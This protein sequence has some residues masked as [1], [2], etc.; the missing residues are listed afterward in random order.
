MLLLERCLL[1]VVLAWFVGIDCFFV[2]AIQVQAEGKKFNEQYNLDRGFFVDHE[3]ESWLAERAWTGCNV[4]EVDETKPFQWG[5]R[6][7]IKRRS[8]VP[9][10]TTLDE[11]FDSA[12]DT[13]IARGSNNN[14]ALI[15]HRLNRTGT[16]GYLKSG[17][18][19]G[20]VDKSLDLQQLHP[21]VGLV[22]LAGWKIFNY[23]RIAPEYD[24]FLAQGLDEG[25][26]MET[27]VYAP[28]RNGFNFHSHQGF[29]FRPIRGKKLFVLA[30]SSRS[31]LPD[32]T[33]Q[34]LRDDAENSQ[35]YFDMNVLP[36]I[37]LL[38]KYESWF[39][40][41]K[42][43]QFCLV[44]EGDELMVPHYWWHLTVSVGDSLSFSAFYNK[45]YPA[46]SSES[47]TCP[48]IGPTPVE[49]WLWTR[50]TWINCISTAE[51]P[52]DAGD[53]CA[54]LPLAPSNLSLTTPSI[55]DASYR[56]LSSWC[57]EDGND[58][59]ADQVL[60]VT[61]E[62]FLQAAKEG[63]TENA[64][65]LSLWLEVWVALARLVGH[66]S[67]V[68]SLQTIDSRAN[69]F[70]STTMGMLNVDKDFTSK[71]VLKN[72]PP[73]Q[74]LLFGSETTQSFLATGAHP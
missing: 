26:D 17:G 28:S 23:E 57:S 71:Q 60:Q 56:F 10:S 2:N 3:F 27:D 53:Y 49:S 11:F 12:G 36:S 31:S 33:P 61:A 38:Q 20:R 45:D 24:D 72:C 67:L 19:S 1:T 55:C 63:G 37:V 32:E 7:L 50:R 52:V 22:G 41:T 35:F 44:G 39:R 62:Q 69:D 46:A 73:I 48:S 47:E 25:T 15:V 4:E 42:G 54:H 16:M 6:P 64:H 66:Q 59:K 5:D 9:S 68:T 74:R 43:L 51:K 70:D 18:K 65:A 29:K 13:V 21:E 14:Q 8:P 30:P 34:E 58:H 40:K